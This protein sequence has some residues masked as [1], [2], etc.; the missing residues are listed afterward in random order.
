MTVTLAGG[1]IHS[2]AYEGEGCQ[3]AL[4]CAH[5]LVERVHGL[6]VLEAAAIGERDLCSGLSV[7]SVV[8]ADAADVALDAF[9]AALSEA[10]SAGAKLLPEASHPASALVPHGSQRSA[11]QV[12]VVGMSGGVDSTVAAF[13]LRTQGYAVVGTTLVLWADPSHADEDGCCSPKTVRRA[14]RVAHELGLPHLTIDATLP[15]SQQVVRYFVDSYGEGLTPNPC[16]KCNARVRFTAMMHVMESVGAAHIATGHYARMWGDPPRLAR[17]RDTHKDQSYVLAEVPPWLLE[18]VLFPVGE[19][20]KQE[21]RALAAENS[22]EGSDAP[23]SQEICFASN[24]DHKRFLCE[25]LGERP[26]HI[27]DLMGRRLGEHKGSYN[28]TIGQ[29]KGLGIAS[30]EPLYVVAV[31]PERSEVVVGPRSSLGVSGMLV[32]D[33]VWH[34]LDEAAAAGERSPQGLSVQLRSSG[35]AYPVE[36][37]APVLRHQGVSVR[38]PLM[39][40]SLPVALTLALGLPADGIA[41]GQTAVLYRDNHVVAAGTIRHTTSD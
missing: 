8:R 1:L 2:A 6:P 34:R 18:R 17:A 5:E 24:D 23:D 37:M 36:E 4:D 35:A 19:F 3:S 27:V 9:H 30:P 22:L 40:Q 14:R 11:A 41:A 33:L 28:Y 12:V 29:R 16:I 39:P 15:F 25:R 7:G 31:D 10:I 26:G 13:L 20:T 38:D 21:I 32:D